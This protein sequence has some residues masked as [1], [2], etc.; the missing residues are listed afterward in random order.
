MSIKVQEK[1]CGNYKTPQKE[2][3]NEELVTRIK[4]GIDTADNM[5]LLWQQ[6]RGIIHKIANRYRNLDSI[7]DLEQEGFIGLCKAVERYNPAAGTLFI[8]Y[9]TYWIKQTIFQY[10]EVSGRIVRIPSVTHTMIRK[11][12]RLCAQFELLHNR[13]PSECEIGRLLGINQKQVWQLLKDIRMGQIGSLDNVLSGD[14]EGIT[15]GDTVVSPQDF[16]EDVLSDV[17]TGQLQSGLWDAVDK[18]EEKWAVVI[19]CRFQ[20]D[21]TR[22]NRGTPGDNRNKSAS[23]SSKRDKRIKEK[24]GGAAVSAGLW[25]YPG[26]GI[27]W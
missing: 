19:R 5:A 25:I 18:L 4:A 26:K 13:A 22:R 10:L 12:K 27:P 17:A 8:T 9:A 7:E 20:E 11:Y 23:D 24:S 15:V 2:Q 14:K 6:N 21:C 3:S 16:E 1:E